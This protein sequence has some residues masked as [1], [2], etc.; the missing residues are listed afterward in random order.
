MFVR[1]S[2]TDWLEPEGLTLD[3]SVT[4]AGWVREAGGD[5]MDVS[6]GGNIAGAT[7]PVGPGYQVPHASAIK[8]GAQII[9]AA[10]GMITSAAQAESIVASGKAD[11]VFVARQFMRDPHLPM[12]WA[13]E[14]GV[15]IELPQQYIPRGVAQ[16]RAGLAAGLEPRHSD[17]GSPLLEARRRNLGRAPHHAERP[18]D[19]DRR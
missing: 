5:V 3:E 13:H 8:S 17:V 16:G 7:I 19:G 18:A 15:E 6:T 2:A 11:A 12:R 4:V 1:V 14:L 10:V 9:T